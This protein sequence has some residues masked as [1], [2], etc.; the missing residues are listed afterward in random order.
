MGAYLSAPDTRKESEGGEGGSSRAALALLCEFVLNSSPQP[1]RDPSLYHT[2]LQLYLSEGALEREVRGAGTG[3]T[4][5]KTT[6][7]KTKTKTTKR[8]CCCCLH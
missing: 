6:T 5:T 4:T 2:L 7:T 1:P 3:A 8:S